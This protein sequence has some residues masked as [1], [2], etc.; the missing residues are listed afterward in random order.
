[1]V[2]GCGTNIELISELGNPHRDRLQQGGPRARGGARRSPR[3]GPLQPHAKE[4]RMK[5][6][7]LADIQPF[8]GSGQD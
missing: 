2:I 6:L 3:V 8:V 5:T 7:W 4:V 1:M